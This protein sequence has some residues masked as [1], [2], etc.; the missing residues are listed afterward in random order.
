MSIPSS[1]SHETSWWWLF[2]FISFDNF[3]F[4]TKFTMRCAEE[5]YSGPTQIEPRDKRMESK[6]ETRQKTVYR[7]KNSISGSGTYVY[8]VKREWS[9]SVEWEEII[10]RS[11]TEL[12]EWQI[13]E[14]G[15]LTKVKVE[16]RRRTNQC[17]PGEVGNLTKVKV[18]IK[19]RT[20][21]CLP[22]RRES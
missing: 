7:A 6:W 17:K 18:E 9:G 4:I 1:S 2:S 3:F 20:N 14:E 22:L 11:R 19:K 15:T 21:Q 5:Q 8:P 16:I 13:A 12:G 10:N